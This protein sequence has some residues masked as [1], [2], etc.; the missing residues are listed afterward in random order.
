M[1]IKDSP[2]PLPTA[3]AGEPNFDNIEILWGE[4]VPDGQVLVA[5]EEKKFSDKA[6][7]YLLFSL[8]YY[9]LLFFI[10]VFY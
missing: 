3:Q 4:M 5:G 7:V 8:L 9:P 10:I 2:F 1:T 6:K